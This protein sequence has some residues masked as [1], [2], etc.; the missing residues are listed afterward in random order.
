MHLSTDGKF[1]KINSLKKN[2]TWYVHRD[3]LHL[4]L[5]GLEQRGK[6]IGKSYML[7]D[8]K[9]KDGDVV[10]DCGANMGDL[11]LYF[12]SK[13]IVINYI[14]F[15]PNPLDYNCLS[16]NLL[17]NSKSVNIALWNSKS[18]LNFYVDSKSASSSLIEPPFFSEVIPVMASRLDEIE[19]PSSIKLLKVEGEGAEPEILLGSIGVLDRIEY[20]SVDAG[21]ERGILQFSTK[22]EVSDTLERNGFSLIKENPFHRKTLLFRDKKLI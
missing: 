7:D 22:T 9:F 4:Y 6:S 10:L 5:D 19:L 13:K 8:I 21:P 12:Y 3:R 20:I 2:L 15:E 17:N 18:K 11:Q 16:R 1:V 14:G